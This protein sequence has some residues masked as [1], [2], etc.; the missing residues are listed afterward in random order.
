MDVHGLLWISYN[1]HE[2]NFDSQYIPDRFYSSGGIKVVAYN[3][4]L[5]F[6]DDCNC[7]TSGFVGAN[8]G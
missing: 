6:N 2:L 7:G 1:Y 8:N 3:N 5:N 4:P